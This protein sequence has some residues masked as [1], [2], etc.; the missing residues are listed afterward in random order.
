MRWVIG[1]LSLYVV[2]SSCLAPYDEIGPSHSDTDG[3]EAQSPKVE[4]QDDAFFAQKLP[5]DSPK[6]F[7]GDLFVRAECQSEAFCSNSYASSVSL[8]ITLDYCF[9]AS[10]W[11]S[12]DRPEGDV[13]SLADAV[14]CARSFSLPL[15]VALY[16]ARL[17]SFSP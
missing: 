4:P 3:L 12:S 13:N 2:F 5:W 1:L 7:Y 16:A 14:I 17:T 8:A 15:P 6:F 11:G 9:G 10:V